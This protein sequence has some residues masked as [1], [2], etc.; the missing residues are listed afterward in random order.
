MTIR[1]ACEL[2]SVVPGKTTSDDFKLMYRR[3]VKEH[4]PDRGGNPEKFRCIVEA[5]AIIEKSGVLNSKGFFGNRTTNNQR[6][7]S[8]NTTSNT[9]Q[10]VT[11]YWIDN[12]G[13]RE[14]LT[15]KSTIALVNIK[16][17]LSN[18]NRTKEDTIRM[19]KI[20]KILSGRSGTINGKTVKIRF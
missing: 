5:N 6:V 10:D 17:F 4:H 18:K 13:R 3:A 16:R 19:E 8:S 9:F 12:M 1:E 11:D 2:M 20:E 15:S 14:L 7:H